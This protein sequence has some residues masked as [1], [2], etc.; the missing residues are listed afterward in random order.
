M[1]G[2]S[3]KNRLFKENIEKHSRLRVKRTPLCKKLSKIGGSVGWRGS[4]LR[5]PPVVAPLM[6]PRPNVICRFC[7]RGVIWG[8][9]GPQGKRKKEKRKK[10]KEKR[11]KKEKWRK[12]RKKGTMNNVK[13]LHIKCCFFQFFNSPVALKNKKKF[14][15]PPPRKSWNDAPVLHFSYVYMP[16]TKNAKTTNLICIY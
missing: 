4:C 2:K 11:E 3:W 15:P 13:L 12:K 7:I 6:L 5:H 10:K 14:A 1:K 9:W 16:H 8:G